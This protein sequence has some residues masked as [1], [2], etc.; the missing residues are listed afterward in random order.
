MAT[1]TITCGGCGKRHAQEI[2]DLLAEFAISSCPLGWLRMDWTDDAGAPSPTPQP[3]KELH[4]C[5][6]CKPK[7]LAALLPL[8]KESKAFVLYA[9]EAVTILTKDQSLGPI[10]RAAEE[11]RDAALVLARVVA[12]HVPS[13]QREKV[14]RVIQS[15]TVEGAVVM[16]DAILDAMCVRDK[17][18]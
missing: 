6:A 17:P 15:S 2:D 4:F 8:R 18:S 12:A 9:G 13:D 3:L 11:L 7:A 5:E 16:G 1:S 14:S 10:S